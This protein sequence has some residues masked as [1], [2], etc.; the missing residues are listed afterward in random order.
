ML[1]FYFSGGIPSV[2]DAFFE[3]MSGFTTTG[4]TILDDI[5]SL[6]HGLLFWRSLTQWIGGLGIVF[7][8]YCCAS[9]FR[10]EELYNFFSAEAIGVTHDKTHPRIDVMAKWLWMIYAILTVVETML[11]M[12]GGM[13]FF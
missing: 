2:T 11:L 1:P 10:G 6:S 13:S 9:Y 8:Y 5:E 7:F 4:A 12:I 3:T